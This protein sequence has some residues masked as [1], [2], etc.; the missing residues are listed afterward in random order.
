MTAK[1]HQIEH[2]TGSTLSEHGCARQHPHE[3]QNLFN[4]GFLNSLSL[5]SGE[6]K[7]GGKDFQIKPKASAA[8][9]KKPR[10]DFD[11]DNLIVQYGD[12]PDSY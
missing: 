3:K 12:H 1:P 2:G 5:N 10:V 7:K 6:P 9:S 8:F 4:L 11:L